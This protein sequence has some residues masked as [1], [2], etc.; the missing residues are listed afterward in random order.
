[1]RKKSRMFTF[2]EV[3]FYCCSLWNFSPATEVWPI[4][5]KKK[6]WKRRLCSITEI[7]Y[8]WSCVATCEPLICSREDPARP[9]PNPAAGLSLVTDS[10]CQQ[11]PP[12]LPTFLLLDYY[13]D[14]LLL[15]WYGGGGDESDISYRRRGHTLPCQ[16]PC[17][18]WQSHSCRL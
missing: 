14:L 4:L 13:H 6:T 15:S 8:C 12:L 10:T 17:W 18:S 7:S 9:K 11:H 2:R 16:T 3:Y 1:M 5:E